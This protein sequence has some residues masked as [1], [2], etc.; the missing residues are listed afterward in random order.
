[1]HCPCNKVKGRARALWSQSHARLAAS[2]TVSATLSKSFILPTNCLLFLL[3]EHTHT[4]T[5]LALVSAQGHS[6]HHST[7]PYPLKLALEA[8]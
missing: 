1:M 4:Y 5:E 8:T 7:L 6:Q 2:V 3:L